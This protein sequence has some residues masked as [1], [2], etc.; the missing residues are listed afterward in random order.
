MDHYYVEQFDLVDRYVMGK[1]PAE[2]SARFEEH[3]LDC[4]QCIERLKTTEDF[5]QDLRLVTIEQASQTDGNQTKRLHEP[6]SQSLSSKTLALTAFFLLVIAIAGTILIVNQMQLLRSEVNEAKRDSAEWQRR[7]DEQMQ[8]DTLSDKMLEET[9]RELT[10]RVIELEARL[11]NEQGQE[12]KEAAA[13]GDWASP[14]IN[15]PIVALNT[16]R[17]GE[18]NSSAAINEIVLSRSPSSFLIIL[19]LEGEQRH[20]DYRVTIRDSNH[21]LILK[22]RGLVPDP[23]NS[24]TIRFDSRFFRPGNYSL[25]VEGLSAKGA[26]SQIGNYP[27]RIV[28]DS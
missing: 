21:Q 19:S 24:L 26:S 7:H 11:Q 23:Y 9:K 22:R 10:A 15:V 4:P 16:V 28:K 25:T 3:F 6:F 14:Q 2:E 12:A 5:L 1:L 13:S 20:E 18:P 8:A 17:G 27:L